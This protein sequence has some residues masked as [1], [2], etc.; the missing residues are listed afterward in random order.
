MTKIIEAQFIEWKPDRKKQPV[1]NLSNQIDDDLIVID[2]EHQT[3]V[4]AQISLSS[5]M[6][7]LSRQ[8][9]QIM[10]YQMEW[11]NLDSARLSGIISSNRVFGTLA[12]EKLRQRYLCT[13][14]NLD[15][16]QPELI[17][18][19]DQL[20]VNNF[21]T[22]QEIDPQRAK[23]HEEIVE[24][25][26]HPDWLIAG[27][28]FTSGVINYLSALPYHKDRGNFVGS[29]SMMLSLRK[30]IQGGY[31]HLPEY[32]LL[33]GVPN[34]SVTFFNG[35]TLWHGVTPFVATKKDAYRFTIVWYAKTKTHQCGCKEN[36][37][38]RAAAE[39]SRI[40]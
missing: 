22:F 2:K 11:G 31:L 40:L 32:D 36:E 21:K 35:Q 1:P 39:A 6:T 28:P 38:K 10:R 37:L 4:L 33:L 29:W 18:L 3:I 16:E 23:N 14:A 9:Q 24:Q 15:K 19:L 25:Q 17:K 34:N 12:P 8:A 13:K 7:K 26:V 27:T 30:N 20:A 5:E